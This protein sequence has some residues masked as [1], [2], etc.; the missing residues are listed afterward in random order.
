MM[1]LAA[2]R[3]ST[4][5]RLGSAS[6]EH[7][8]ATDRAGGFD[9]G[10]VVPHTFKSGR[11]SVSDCTVVPFCPSKFDNR[12]PN[13]VWGKSVQGEDYISQSSNI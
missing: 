11:S 8:W 10:K 2:I 5:Q 4:R 1:A 7:F 12:W 3:K 9:G 6:P 13:V